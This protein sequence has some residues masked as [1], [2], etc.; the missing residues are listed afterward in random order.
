M[1]PEPS[2]PRVDALVEELLKEK[3]L[4][5]IFRQS[6]RIPRSKVNIFVAVAFCAVSFCLAVQEERASILATQVHSLAAIILVSTIGLLG[7]LI[8]GF[9]FF[10]T[11]SDKA[12]FCRMAEHS[13][14]AS[15][16]SYLKYN[17]FM[18]LRVFAQY[19][20]MSLVSFGLVVTLQPDSA[21][22]RTLR[23]MTE[24]LTWPPFLNIATPLE[25]VLLAVALSLLIGL[26]VFVLMELGAFVFNVYH[27]VMTSIAWELEKEAETKDKLVQEKEDSHQMH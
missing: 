7:F 22:R 14:K 2:K 19:L 10:A 25:S 1:S 24:Q 4:W 13:H 21:I 8:A 15:G 9:S 5:A 16:L 3:T 26:F 17:L 27:V 20:L 18:F 6:Q 11:V 23:S 12:M